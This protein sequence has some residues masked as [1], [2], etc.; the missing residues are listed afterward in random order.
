MLSGVLLH[1][2]SAALEIDAAVHCGAWQGQLRRRFQ[3]VNDPAILGIRNLRD[4]Q[5][6][7]PFEN[8]PSGVVNLT[9]AGGIERGFAQDYGWARL[10][11]RRGSDFLDKRI[12]F[13]D[14][15]TVVVKTL[16]HDEGLGAPGSGPSFG[17]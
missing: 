3:V 13:V 4:S 2:V 15:R 7:G 17:R 12:E 8:Q 6:L 5:A 14:F 11:R 9:A 1:V 16:C 10:L